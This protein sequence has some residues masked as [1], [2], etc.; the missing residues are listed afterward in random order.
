MELA[1]PDDVANGG[2][3]DEDFI[4]QHAVRAVGGRQQLLDDDAL[5]RV[6]ELEDDLFLGAAIE[7]PGDAFDRLGGA[8]RVQGAE[9]E[10]ARFRSG[11]RGHDGFRF[12]HFPDHDDIGILPQDM[13]QGSAERVGIGEQFLLHDDG[14]LIDMHVFDRVFDGDDFAAALVVDEVHH[15]VERGRCSGTGRSADEHEAVWF[16][17]EV[18]DLVRQS[19][20]LAGGN[21]T[22]AKTKAEL[23]A[24][25]MF[26]GGNAQTAGDVVI[27]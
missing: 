6:G 8:G 10:V 15:V 14:L 18:V 26:V 16:A 12:T 25:V 13:C 24:T 22:A 7:D 4:G 20:F 3:G 11:E 27:Q 9:H 1:F 23:N 2:S 17:G 21:I 19:K 5:E